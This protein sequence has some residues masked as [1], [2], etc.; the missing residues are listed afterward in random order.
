M[1]LSI[2]TTAE[3]WI[4]LL[5]LTFL[6]IVLGVD[7]IIFISIVS[8]KLPTEQQ[9]RARVWGLLIALG[10]RIAMLLGISIIIQFKTPLFTIPLPNDPHHSVS[11][12]DLILL[13]GGLFLMAKSTKEIH[14][15]ME[16][17]EEENLASKAT[18]SLTSVI[19]QIILLDIIFSFDSIL[20]AVGLTEHVILMIIA[21]VI[22]LGVMI[23]FSGK[24]A[25]F[26]H[27]HPTMEILAL[28][29][30]ILI[31]VMLVA[32]GMGQHIEKG[33]IYFGVAF[34]LIIEVLNMRVRKKA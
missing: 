12:R 17:N 21:V 9:Q 10:F 7:N 28:S 32:E 30:L 34:S 1:D 26:I 31:G 19:I 15:K 22:S 27:K 8:N 14:N 4:A 24:I 20:T 2:F 25:S 3:A 23:G 33:Y 29:F 13:L 5:T 18:S 11:G 6:E 16:G